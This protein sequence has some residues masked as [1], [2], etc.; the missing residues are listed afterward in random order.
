MDLVGKTAMVTGAGRGMGRAIALVLASHGAK[1]AAADLDFSSVDSLS[2][3]LHS[4][5]RD[6]LSIRMDVADPGDVEAAVSKAMREL[7][8]IDILVNNAGIIRS[9][10]LSDMNEQDWDSISRVNVKGVWLCT[11]AVVPHMKSGKWG[12]VI[13]ISSQAAKTAEY[14]NGAY[15]IS[16]AAVSMMTQ[17]WALELAEYGINVNAICPGY[18]DTEMM[19]NV[20][21]TRGPIE[22][23][24]A[25]EYK[26]AL[27]AGVPLRRMAKPSEIGELVAFLASEKAAYIT[28]A[29]VLITG[30]KEMH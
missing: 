16:K 22:G 29:D 13:N 12:R 4:I 7:G 18:T 24:T 8:R 17:V 20:F 2:D 14:G 1:I 6:A 23:M 27:L 9:S 10:L 5:G 3:E 25:E 21:E 15:C 30:G 26:E 19:Q 28:G 11:R